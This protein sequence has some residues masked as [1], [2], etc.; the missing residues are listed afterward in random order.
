ML[1]KI[2]VVCFGL[3]GLLFLPVGALLLI[4]FSF[5]FFGRTAAASEFAEFLKS[6]K[7]AWECFTNPG[8]IDV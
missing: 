4:S 1:R 5:L 8:H 2:G 6:Y 3:I 7:F